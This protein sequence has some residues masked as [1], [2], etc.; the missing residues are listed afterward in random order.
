MSTL[1]PGK[2]VVYRTVTTK[3]STFLSF[4][5]MLIAG[6]VYPQSESKH[7]QVLKIP[8]PNAAALINDFIVPVNF[9]RGK[10]DIKLPLLTLELNGLK[11]P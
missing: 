11:V 2:D 1:I 4:F 3:K 7:T 10:P 6:T 9:Y 5:V 8:T